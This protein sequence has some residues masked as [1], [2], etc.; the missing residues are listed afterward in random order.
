M[1]WWS[2]KKAHGRISDLKSQRLR[3][4]TRIDTYK[5]P[6]RR[7]SRSLQLLNVLLLN[8]AAARQPSCSVVLPVAR[9]VG[10]RSSEVTEIFAEI[11]SWLEWWQNHV[12]VLLLRIFNPKCC[13]IKTNLKVERSDSARFW[14]RLGD[15]LRFQLEGFWFFLSDSSALGLDVQGSSR[16]S[17]SSLRKIHRARCQRLSRVDCFLT[18]KLTTAA[19]RAEMRRFTPQVD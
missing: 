13:R 7:S 14:W 19:I 4:S 3:R 9:L 16:R 5:R 12:F 8:Y 11:F 2:E 6:W 1:L 15:R 17:L 10:R 18:R